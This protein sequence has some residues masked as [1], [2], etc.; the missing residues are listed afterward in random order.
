MPGARACFN[1]HCPG[2]QKA[3]Y[4]EHLCAVISLYANQPTM[5]CD[6]KNKRLHTRRVKRLVGLVCWQKHR[7]FG[8]ERKTIATLPTETNRRSRGKGADSNERRLGCAP[9]G[10]LH[11]CVRR[12]L[13]NPWPGKGLEQ[14]RS[15][16]PCVSSAM[17]ETGQAS[18]DLHGLWRTGKEC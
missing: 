15:A 8:T 4:T 10:A 1:G 17:W 7:W 12:A 9:Q 6:E 11:R 13:Y 2:G 14:R 3:N 5:Q 18:N 16:D